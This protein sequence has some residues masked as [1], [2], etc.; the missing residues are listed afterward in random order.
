MN[1]KYTCCICGK[2][3]DDFG[4]NPEGAAWIDPETKSVVFGEFG[5]NDRCCDSCDM[6]FVLPGRLYRLKK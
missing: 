5:P 2:E 4:N 6:S 1:N 3:F